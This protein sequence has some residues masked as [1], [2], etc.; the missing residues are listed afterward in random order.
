MSKMRWTA[1]VLLGLIV[2]AVAYQ[3]TTIGDRNAAVAQDIESNPDGDRAKRAMLL[4][5]EDDRM[6]PVNYLKEGNL[7][8]VGID[9]LWWREFEGQGAPVRLLIRGEQYHGHAKTVLDDPAY[10][11]EI[12]ARLRPTAPEW[13]P[14]WLNGKLV[15][16]KLKD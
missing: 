7:V 3:V 2:L 6:F 14:D 5:L 9:G 1:V 4:Y 13:L 15:V 8:F 10:K 11:E 16:I 12:F